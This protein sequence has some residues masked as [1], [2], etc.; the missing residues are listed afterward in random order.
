MNDLTL[1][2]DN[3][4]SFVY[5]LSHHIEDLGSKAIVLRSDKVTLEKV[6][7]LKPS[8]IVLSP[9][10]GNPTTLD[11]AKYIG[12]SAEIVKKFSGKIPILGVCLG[13][14]IIAHVY[15]AKIIKAKKTVHGKASFI[16]HNG[17]ILFK[18]IPRLFKA[19]RYHS[20]AID[21]KSLP[22]ELIATAWTLDDNE[23]MAIAHKSYKTFG[24]QFHPESIMTEYGKKILKNFLEI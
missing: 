17:N 13:H 8:R 24:I 20:L 15:G 19:I 14:Q 1:I 18:G 10:P 3:Y 23:L 9:G 5:N 7:S 11:G 16:V 4:D 22:N 6:K 12:I 21:A 2:L